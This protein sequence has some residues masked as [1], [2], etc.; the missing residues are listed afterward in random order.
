M[1]G[2][3]HSYQ[4]TNQWQAALK[5]DAT[6]LREWTALNQ[7]SPEEVLVPPDAQQITTP[8]I[9]QQWSSLLATYPDQ[10][11][12]NFFMQGLTNGFRIGYRYGNGHL[13]SAT[14]NMASAILHPKVVEEY[15]ANEVSLS[16][17][18][19]PY[20]KHMIKGG[21][22]S[23]FG[24][25][26]KHNK[27]DAWRLIVDMSHPEGKSVND[28]ITKSLCS[29]QYVTIE[30]AINQV[31]KLGQ[32]SLLAKVDIKSAFRLLPV[33]P[34]DRHLLQMAW[35]DSIYVDTCLPF[36]MRSAPKL[37]NVAADLLQWGMQ[38][39]GVSYIMHYLDDFLTF[40]HPSSAECQ[41]NLDTIMHTCSSLGVP[42]AAEKIEGPS[43]TLTFLGITID[44]IKMEVRLPDDKLA[45]IRHIVSD[46]L[47]KRRAKKR[48]ILSLVGLL[49]HATKVVQCGR[50]FVSRMYSTAAKIKKMDYKKR[51]NVE[52]RSDLSWWHTFLDSWNGLSLLRSSAL[53]K[54]PDH[55]IQ[56][57]ASGSWGCGA[58]FHGQWFQLQWNTQWKPHHIMV[59]EL[60]PVVLSAAVWGPQLKRQRVMFQ[61]DNSSVVTSLQKGS[62]K[63]SACMQ[64]LRCLWFFKAHYDLDLVCEHIPG[65]S[66]NT[67]DHL[68][69]NNIQAFR[70][71]NP[72]ASHCPTPLPCEL[73]R[74]TDAPGPDWTSPVF[75]ALF[76][77]VIK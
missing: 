44:T 40:G 19:G 71:M 72:D 18:A 59:K 31:L 36:G 68:S 15:I 51:L 32:G 74:I 5:Q 21:Q 66:N 11:M 63:D 37:F 29:L 69:R 73:L 16:R 77:K 54:A 39:Q 8:L 58:Y 52:F 35:D 67:A 42:L 47:T 27:M 34:A 53:P 76:S 28:G 4:A 70:S 7:Q 26:P 64:L 17:V 65:S 57:D 56:T 9:K 10:D 46:W 43:T 24:V 6:W 62:S 23:R 38:Q 30:D 14:K 20:R 55:Y 3:L 22:I 13:K 41:N 50:T 48:E 33:H 2:R 1:A 60:L 25:I 75:R 49:Q 45:R 61:C 12:A